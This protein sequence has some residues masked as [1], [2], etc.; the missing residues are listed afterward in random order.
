MSSKIT[1]VFKE[2]EELEKSLVFKKSS[3]ISLFAYLRYFLYIESIGEGVSTN[4]RGKRLDFMLLFKATFLSSWNIF[5][6]LKCERIVFLSSR[7]KNSTCKYTG[8]Y[9]TE[10]TFKISYDKSEIPQKNIFYLHPLKLL[11]LFISYLITLINLNTG[12]SKQ[13]IEFAKNYKSL[14]VNASFLLRK[15]NEFYI[16]RLF[17]RFLFIF[18]KP[19]EIYFTSNN[20]FIPLINVCDDKEIKTIEIAHALI[21]KYHPSYSYISK[22]RKGILPNTYIENIYSFNSNIKFPN[23]LNFIPFRKERLIISKKSNYIFIV[24]QPGIDFKP[25][26]KRLLT[27]EFIYSFK[28]IYI[29]HPL[30]KVVLPKQLKCITLEEYHN[31]FDEKL[32]HSIIGFSSNLLIEMFYD[33]M[34]VFSVDEHYS[35]VFNSRI[36]KIHLIAIK[37]L[38][39]FIFK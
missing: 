21:H 5:Q 12:F 31:H 25:L 20:F 2:I 30:E 26:I 15:T 29:K 13:I 23:D 27:K 18:N 32:K 9:V 19:K 34:D 28:V 3:E 33:G 35:E 11:V 39:P 37:D 10:S 6:F 4:Q 38:N 17:W 1:R 36:E 24:G 7:L 14:Q 8:D 22:K 16:W